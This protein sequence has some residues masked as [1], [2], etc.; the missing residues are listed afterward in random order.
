M[1]QNE[2]VPL[3]SIAVTIAMV[4]G[5][6]VLLL[7]AWKVLRVLSW[8]VV[9]AFLAAV[10]GPAVDV[11]QRRLHLARSLATLVVFLLG[12]LV[13]AGLL[14]LMVR[15]IAREGT[16]FAKTVPTVVEQAR[17]G[18]GPIGRLVKR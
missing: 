17:T 4:L 13:L 5:T 1:D 3:R 9:S 10:L 16:D 7:L 2:R 12:A 18:R 11:A 14:T 6:V 15:P 8:I